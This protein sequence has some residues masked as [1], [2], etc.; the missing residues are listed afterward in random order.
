MN[1]CLDRELMLQALL[2][3]ELDAANALTVE[4]HLKTCPGCGAYF[5]TLQAL[6]TPLETRGTLRFEAPDSLEQVTDPGTNGV[7]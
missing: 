4:S 1:P 3:G 6:R 7:S 2:D 5:R